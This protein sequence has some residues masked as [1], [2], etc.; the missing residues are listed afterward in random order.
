MKIEDIVSCLEEELNKDLIPKDCHCL[1]LHKSIEP[2]S[3]N[4]YTKYVYVLYDVIDNNK[5]RL[6]SLNYVAKNEKNEKNEEYL[7]EYLDKTFL[8]S[9]IEF[10][11]KHYN[12]IKNK[13]YEAIKV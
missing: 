12:N 13:N 11:V 3:F 9:L 6:L 10:I 2:T 4:A 1:V 8:K 7:R 5:L